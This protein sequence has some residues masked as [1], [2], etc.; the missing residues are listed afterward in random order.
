V[1]R[2]GRHLLAVIDD[3]LDI[4]SIESGTLSM[5]VEPVGLVELLEETIALVNPLAQ[6]GEVRL[7][8]VG[9]PNDDLHVLADRRR[10][11]QV[12]LNLASN[13]IKFNQPGGVVTFQCSA[14]ANGRVRLD[15]IDT[16]RGIAEDMLD[17][18]F[19]PF[20]RLGADQTDVEGTGIG[21]ALSQRLAEA[22]GGSIT[23]ES[24]LGRGST[25]SLDLPLSAPIATI[26]DAD[27][28]ELGD[29]GRD[30]PSG[31]ILYIEDNP[32]NLKLV[33]RVIERRPDLCMTS[34]AT[35][36]IGLSLAGRA[37]FDVILLDIH[38]PDMSGETVLRELQQS[39]ATRTTPIV[40]LS[41]DATPG[42]IQRLLDAGAA[43]YLTK[44]LDLRQ[45]MRVVDTAIA[46]VPS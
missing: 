25:F 16:G 6:A 36:A 30:G 29:E 24:D 20:D 11:K 5:S 8:A 46:G 19:T 15:V 45:L 10:L 31:S 38:L 34:A 44:P 40:I 4:S 12:I 7:H 28:A 32:S 14:S 2:G 35:G 9:L 39:E 41:A 17:R 23:V 26:D 1:L 18:L 21:L 42:Q 27:P 22:L 3:V 43:D 33:Q 37:P 13:A